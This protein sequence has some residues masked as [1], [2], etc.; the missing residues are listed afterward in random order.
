[1]DALILGCGVVGTMVGELLVARG[2]RVMGVRRSAAQADAFPILRGDIADPAWWEG[3]AA[4]MPRWPVD[5]VLL[6]ANPGLFL[7]AI[8]PVADRLVG[9]TLGT[10]DGR[11]GQLYHVAVE[12]AY[13]RQ[14]IAILLERV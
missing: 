14:G 10:F 9:T 1:M 8:D 6:A 7:V 5:A 11:R 3:I 12:P 4:A 13:R 2:D